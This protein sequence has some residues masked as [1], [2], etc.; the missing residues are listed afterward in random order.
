M[1]HVWTLFLAGL[2]ALC[3]YAGYRLFCE[4][5]VTRRQGAPASLA[6]VILLNMVPGALLALFG[7]GLFTVEARGMM[8]RRPGI[9]YQTPSAEGTSWHHANARRWNQ[10]A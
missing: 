4:L 7:A 9:R 10:A 6:A 8:T 1:N 3:I 2:G 5:P